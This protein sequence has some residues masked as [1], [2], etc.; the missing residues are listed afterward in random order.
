MSDLFCKLGAFQFA[1]R[2]V[3]VGAQPRT[4]KVQ[5][6]ALATEPIQTIDYVSGYTP[7]TIEG[8]LRGFDTINETSMA[9]LI[10]L[11]HNLKTEVAKDSNTLVIT[12]APGV[13]E[14]YRVFKNEDF[15]I[16]IPAESRM[17][18][19]INFTLTLNCLP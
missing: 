9:H 13:I 11:K 3:T 7:I 6:N 1:S 14:T 19:I 17:R 16:V 8:F 18:R 15:D 10:R 5:T 12:W 4:V 2:S